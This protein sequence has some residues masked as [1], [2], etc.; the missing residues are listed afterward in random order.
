MGRG[1]N[2]DLKDFIVHNGRAEVTKS[3]TGGSSFVEWQSDCKKLD[4][5]LRHLFTEKPLYVSDL[6]N[7]LEGVQR[8]EMHLEWFKTYIQ[9][10]LVFAPS[11]NRSN[12][13][14]K[15]VR[16]YESMTPIDQNTFRGVV[17]SVK[18]MRGLPEKFTKLITFNKHC[19]IK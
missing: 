9:N 2:I 11:Y 10:H 18:L 5:I 19:N 1:G 14:S 13:S 12:V 3:P 6:I 4:S 15:I 7:T 17:N 8:V 16:M